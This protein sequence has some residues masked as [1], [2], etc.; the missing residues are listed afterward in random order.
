MTSN[1]KKKLTIIVPVYNE[2]ETILETLH[3]IK[4]TKDDR[5][6]Y[7]TI[8]VNDGSTDNTLNLLNSNTD[9]YEYLI[10]GEKNLGKGNA[11]RKGLEISTGDY[12]IFQDADLEYDPLD[13]KYFIDIILKFNADVI[14]GS[15]F[16][17]SKYMRSINILNRAGNYLLTFLFNI[18][19]NVTFTDICCCY[20]C[21]K[22]E[23]LDFNS[24]KTNGF[25]Q[26]AE[27]LCKIIKKGK[28]FFEVPTNH[29]ARTKLEGKKIRFYHIFPLILRIVVERIR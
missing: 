25:D 5:V 28:I 22:R 23:L 27:I 24:L 12:V 4:A 2:E 6:N 13:F 3:R 16:K 10:N 29:N 26:H 15:R 1:N 18:F 19:Y 20:L 21:F 17:Y 8:V 9:L 11:V 14:I 7:E